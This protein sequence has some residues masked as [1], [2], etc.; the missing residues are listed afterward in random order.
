M[1]ANLLIPL[2]FMPPIS[3]EAAVFYLRSNSFGVFVTALS[4]RWDVLRRVE[5]FLS[6]LAIKLMQKRANVVQQLFAIR[7][8]RGL[9]Y[10]EHA[11]PAVKSSA[12]LAHSMAVTKKGT[13][14]DRRTANGES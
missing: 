13:K 6:F 12:I 4:L 9:L 2:L 14:H 11:L 8:R 10:V 3:M 1:G 7:G 5:D